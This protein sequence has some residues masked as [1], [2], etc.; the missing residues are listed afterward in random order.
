MGYS[1]PFA[2]VAACIVAAAF[3]LLCTLT[4]SIKAS[5]VPRCA[6][7]EEV[8]FCTATVAGAAGDRF[9]AINAGAA[10]C[11]ANSDDSGTAGCNLETPVCQD[12]DFAQSGLA[13][14]LPLN[15]NFRSGQQFFHSFTRFENCVG[16]SSPECTKVRIG[17]YDALGC[18]ECAAIYERC[19]NFATDCYK[20]TTA[21]LCADA[22][23][24]VRVDRGTAANTS[25][26]A[27]YGMLGGFDFGEAA[28]EE[29][30][31][32][33]ARVPGVLSPEEAAAALEASVAPTPA[34]G[35]MAFAAAAAAAVLLL[36]R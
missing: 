33:V 4:A 36:L 26:A 31:Q 20:A 22:D 2:P 13:M 1:R 7:V 19:I 9:L 24:I 6:W 34:A 30:L 21:E 10:A 5:G 14:C 8:S 32:S 17:M 18:S 28:L 16:R 12:V 35:G 11:L 25:A 23:I 27:D 15:A 3:L 29:D